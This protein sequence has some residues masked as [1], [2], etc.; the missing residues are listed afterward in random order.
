[1]TTPE[2]T[3]VMPAY[4]EEEAIAGVVNEWVERL[5]RMGIDYRLDVR[6]D[7]SRDRTLEILRGLEEQIPRLRVTTRPNAGHGPTVLRAYREAEGEWV[8]QTDSD[9]E[10]SPADFAPIWYRREAYDFLIGRRFHHG[11]PWPRRIV[12]TLARWTVRVSF[13]RAPHDVNVPFRLM[14]RDLLR[15]LLD[16]VPADT[17]APN[18][19]LSGLAAASGLRLFEHPVLHRDRAG[20]QT[21]LDRRAL[22]RASR[23]SLTETLSIAWRWR[24]RRRLAV[25]RRHH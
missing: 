9:G 24:S 21:S 14:Y 7:G 1:M 11:A 3:V 17:F 12:T 10:I 18:V 15:P 16:A 5:D 2:L 13:G 20:G 23:R 6:D 22:L 8:F 4:N 19:A 25:A